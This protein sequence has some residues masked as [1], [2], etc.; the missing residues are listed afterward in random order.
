MTENAK[1]LFEIL[2]ADGEFAEKVTKAGSISAVIALAKDK[3][4]DLSEEDI[5]ET[6]HAAAAMDADELQAVSGGKKC[7]CFTGGGGTASDDKEGQH[8]CA[9]V[10]VGLGEVDYTQG[11]A[12]KAHRCACP[13]YGEGEDYDIHEIWNDRHKEK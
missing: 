1:K 12:F 4:L 11:G 13:V 10:V 7:V 8:T 3:G 2:S 6:T 9:C 5:R